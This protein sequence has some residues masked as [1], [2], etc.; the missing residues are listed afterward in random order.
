MTV[1]YQIHTLRTRI[2][3]D[4]VLHRRNVHPGNVGLLCAPT[5]GFPTTGSPEEVDVLAESERAECLF[6]PTF[7]DYQW[8]TLGGFHPRIHSMP[9]MA[10]WSY[11]P[12]RVL[13][14][15]GA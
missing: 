3:L 8:S 6:T 4:G 7:I 15:L 13:R 1:R 9:T 10:T 14:E 12:D 2:H 11:L 5:T